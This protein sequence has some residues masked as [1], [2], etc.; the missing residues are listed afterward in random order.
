MWRIFGLAAY[1]RYW[2]GDLGAGILGEILQVAATW[3]LAG[4]SP[5]AVGWYQFFAA[6]PVLIGGALLAQLF[7]R[8][9]VQTVMVLDLV[10]RAFAY[11][12]LGAALLLAARSAIPLWAFDLAAAWTALF[13][14]ASSAGGPS[15]WPRLLAGQDVGRAMQAEQLGWN[16][17][18]IA[19]P[20]MAGLVVTATGLPAISLAGAMVFLGLAL[21]LLTLPLRPPDGLAQPATLGA[22][23]AGMRDVWRIV[24]GQRALLLPTLLFWVLNLVG[25]LQG[26]FLPLIVHTFWRGPAWLYGALLGVGAFGGVLG[27]V[28]LA[29]AQRGDLLR[30]VTAW[31]MVASLASL[32]LLPGL[33]RP[34]FAFVALGISGAIGASTA[35]WVLRLRFDATGEQ[36]R[37]VV[38]AYIRTFLYAA[39]PLGALVAGSVWRPASAATWLA[40]GSGLMFAAAA[41]SLAVSACGRSTAAVEASP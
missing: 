8:A 41:L 33:H 11:A 6:A 19:G 31:E 39:S 29:G 40:A 5:R 21:N 9:S 27:S 15:L 30:K 32:L 24:V 14:M 26:V 35:T 37:P 13:L 23:Q 25:G 4:W 17:S 2:F 7:R 18:A 38:L 10:A 20:L 1:R 22:P 16:L 12:L 3:Y 34:L 28:T 36:E